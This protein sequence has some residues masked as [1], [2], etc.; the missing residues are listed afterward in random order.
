LEDIAEGAHRVLN[1]IENNGSRDR[2]IAGYIRAVRQ[3]ALNSQRGESQGMT[4]VLEALTKINADTERLNQRI[5]TIDKTTSTLSTN[6]STATNSQQHGATSQPEIGSVAWP[7][8][9]HRIPTA[10]ARRRQEYRT[11][12]FTRTER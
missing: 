7:G 12:R 10:T 4:K 1:Y 9:R 11:S 8:L 6:V 5:A 3:F 2:H